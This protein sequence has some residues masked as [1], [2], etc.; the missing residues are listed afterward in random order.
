[1]DDLA[2]HRRRIG[3][4]GQS[5]TSGSRLAEDRAQRQREEE[6]TENLRRCKIAAQASVWPGARPRVVGRS[7][8]YRGS[9]SIGIAHLGAKSA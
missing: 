6:Q 8:A 3:I 4:H 7:A 9:P 5:L 1:M 2:A